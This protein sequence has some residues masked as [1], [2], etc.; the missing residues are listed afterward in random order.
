[1]RVLSILLMVV[2]CFIGCQQKVDDGSLAPDDAK[3]YID[4]VKGFELENGQTVKQNIDRAVASLRTKGVSIVENG[5]RTY[6]GPDFCGE[7]KSVHYVITIDRTA[8]K[9][10]FLLKDGGKTVEGQNDGTRALLTP[11]MPKKEPAAKSEAAEKAQ[12]PEKKAEPAPAANPA[13]G[14]EKADVPK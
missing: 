14:P 3:P 1:V 9:F 8:E 13:K 2:V 5:W 12:G 4:Q 11:P 7:C 6:P 10:E